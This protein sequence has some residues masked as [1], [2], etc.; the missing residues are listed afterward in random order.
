VEMD[1]L[2]VEHDLI[3][4]LSCQLLAVVERHP[5]EPLP[6][7]PGES[8]DAVE[9]AAGSSAHRVLLLE[10]VEVRREVV[11]SLGD[12][13]GSF[14]ECLFL[15]ES[16]LVRVPQSLPLGSDSGEASVCSVDLVPE[17]IVIDRFA[18]FENAVRPQEKA[19]VEQMPADLVPH[20]GVERSSA[21]VARVA[22]RVF[23]RG[24]GSPAA[25][26]VVALLSRATFR[27]HT[28]MLAPT[29]GAAKKAAK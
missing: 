4:H 16:S 8:G 29:D 18:V 25:A 7:C 23:R 11:H 19:R 12:L 21:Y 3:E 28:G 14:F 5:V 26:V 6:N 15:E 13:A 22:G 27:A 20:Q 17:D 9:H 10:G 1:L 24:A 2:S